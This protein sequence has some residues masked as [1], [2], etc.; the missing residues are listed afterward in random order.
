MQPPAAAAPRAFTGLLLLYGNLFV[1]S[2]YF[3][4]LSPFSG[5]GQSL[6]GASSTTA[7]A[8]PVQAATVNFSVDDSAPVT[9]IQIR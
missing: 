2:F 4:M 9:N 3:L 8:G 7:A 1:C 6:G 5:A